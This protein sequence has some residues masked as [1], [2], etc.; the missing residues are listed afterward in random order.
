MKRRFLLPVFCVAVLAAAAC[1]R[2]SEKLNDK[3]LARVFN[4]TLYLSDMEG[5]FPPGQD[6]TLIINS[7]VERWIREALLL[8]EAERN[9]P[10]DLNIDKLVRDY[11]ASLVRHSYEQFLVEQLLDSTVTRE[12]L[13]AFYENNKEQYQLETPIMRCF[14]IKIPQPVYRAEELRRLW[15]SNRADDFPKLVQYCS[16]FAESHLLEDSTWYKVEEI[17]AELPEG[18]VSI[19]NPGSKRE[20]TVRDDRYEYFLKVFEWKN[21]Q[22][23]APFSYIENQARRFILRRRMDSLV[24][25]KKNEMYDVE[26]RRG[27]VEIFDIR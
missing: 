25:E 7:Y 22:E 12:E 24:E 5:M 11:R 26:M 23:I 17:A 4:R 2:Q 6:S 19:E 13:E 9:I 27:N 1:G 8:Q 21:R 16:Q 14:F 15:N 10:S 3:P 20:I 18:L